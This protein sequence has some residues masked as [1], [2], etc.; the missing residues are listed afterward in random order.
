MKK[1]DVKKLAELSRIKVS[2]KDINEFTEQLSD[3]LSYVNK[4][5]EYKFVAKKYD[6]Q[7]EIHDLRED[8]IISE[9]SEELINQFSDRSGKLLKVKKIL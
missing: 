2:Q 1:E 4:V 3:I 6:S 5:Q 8:K 9:E 7:D